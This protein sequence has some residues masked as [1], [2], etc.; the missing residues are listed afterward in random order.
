[1]AC[2]NEIASCF[3]SINPYEMKIYVEEDN[4]QNVA[5]NIPAGLGQDGHKYDSAL[6]V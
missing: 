5:D 4:L 2:I 3:L 6:S 1:M